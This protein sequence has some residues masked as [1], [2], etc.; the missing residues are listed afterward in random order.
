[1]LLV[2]TVSDFE[3]ISLSIVGAAV[4]SVRCMSQCSGCKCSCQCSCRVVDYVAARCACTAC[5]SCT[6]ACSCRST[7]TVFEF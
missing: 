4:S 7:E 3:R 5:N 6:C 2:P 1:M